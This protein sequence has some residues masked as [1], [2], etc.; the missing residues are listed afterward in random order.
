MVLVRGRLIRKLVDLLM[1]KFHK[2]VDLLEVK[3]AKPIHI[4]VSLQVMLV[5]MSNLIGFAMVMIIIIIIIMVIML[6]LIGLVIQIVNH[7][8]FTV[9]WM[10]FKVVLLVILIIR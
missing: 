9:K 10:Q 5:H 7:K 6:K 3:R 4:V 8:L 2:L 1:F